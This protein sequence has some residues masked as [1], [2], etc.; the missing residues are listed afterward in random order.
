MPVSTSEIPSELKEEIRQ[1]RINHYQTQIHTRK[2][3]SHQVTEPPVQLGQR[4]HHAK[5]GEGIILAYEGQGVH[6]R[7]QVNFED[8]G[9]KWLVLS[10][11]NLELK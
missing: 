11:A 2:K 6:A 3:T 1:T 4:A 10:Y 8:A 7:V 5:F 9:T